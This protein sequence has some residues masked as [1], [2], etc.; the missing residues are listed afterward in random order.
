M[1][2]PFFNRD[3]DSH[4]NLFKPETLNEYV[5]HRLGHEMGSGR[6]Q[7]LRTRRQQVHPRIGT[8]ANEELIVRFK[9]SDSTWTESVKSSRARGDRVFEYMKYDEEHKTHPFQLMEF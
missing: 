5:P 2:T 3:N 4:R 9:P 1:A 8:G 7:V 6:S